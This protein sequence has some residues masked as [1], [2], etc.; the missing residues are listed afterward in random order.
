MWEGASQVYGGLVATSA[1]AN[2]PSGI[3][4]TNLPTSTDG[5]RLGFGIT[6]GANAA[7]TNIVDYIGAWSEASRF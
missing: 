1:S 3:D 6:T 5:L 4:L 2:A 7:H